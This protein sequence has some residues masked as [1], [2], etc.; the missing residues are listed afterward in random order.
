[1][2]RIAFTLGLFAATSLAAPLAAQSGN[3]PWWDPA[4]TGNR[5]TADTR[6]GTIHDRNGT[7]Y[8]R[9]GRVMDRR[10]TVYGSS[11]ADGQWRRQ[12][13]DRNGN[14]IYVRTR[15]DASGNLVQERALRDTLGRY[16]VIDRRVIRN[17]ND[18]RRD[19]DRDNDRNNDGWEDR[20]TRDRNDRW[21]QNDGHDNGKHNGWYKDKNKDKNKGKSKSKGR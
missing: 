9:N 14:Y 2:K 3:G 11:R 13:R 4:N 21:E 10:G 5:G 19:R 8:D 7:V 16:R 18:R 1:M 12:G 17:V 15:Y 6:N 20:R